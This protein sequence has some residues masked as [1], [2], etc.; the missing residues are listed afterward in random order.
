LTLYDTKYHFLPL[1]W[2]NQGVVKEK[3]RG[4]EAGQSLRAEGEKT[5]EG[6]DIEKQRKDVQCQTGIDIVPISLFLN[7]GDGLKRQEQPKKQNGWN[8]GQITKYES[9][10]GKIPLADQ[11]QKA[12]K[13]GSNEGQAESEDC[14][15]ICPPEFEKFHHRS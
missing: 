15:V 12:R 7:I 3:R 1:L 10:L 5:D 9:C 13:G 11:H 4:I 2:K 8:N 6:A 14:I